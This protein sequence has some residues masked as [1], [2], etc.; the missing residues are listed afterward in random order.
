MNKKLKRAGA[1]CAIVGATLSS[2]GCATVVGTAAGP[3]TNPITAY[4]MSGNLGHDVT[5]RAVL[6]AM[7]VLSGPIYGGIMGARA[8]IYFLTHGEYP[9]H[10]NFLFPWYD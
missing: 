5:T 10:Y 3:I 4:E 1:I 6:T 7:G 9:P 2:G 8:D